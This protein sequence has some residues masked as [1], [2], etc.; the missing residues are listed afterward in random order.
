M[1]WTF[2]ARMVG[3]AAFFG[4]VA[5]ASEEH[6][7]FDAHGHLVWTAGGR[8]AVLDIDAG[9]L[10]AGGPSERI[11]AQFPAPEA[12][13]LHPCGPRTGM[14]AGAVLAQDGRWCAVR[15]GEDGTRLRVFQEGLRLWRADLPEWW[16]DRYAQVAL[17]SSRVVLYDGRTVLDVDGDRALRTYD[18]SA[19]HGA[20]A[21]YPGRSRIAFSGRPDRIV[22]LFEER[23]VEL[24]TLEVSDVAWRSSTVVGTIGRGEA[25]R[26]AVWEADGDLRFVLD[27]PDYGIR[28]LS[29]DGR[30]LGVVF[31]GEGE[32]RAELLD[33]RTGETT[34]SWAVCADGHR[35][36]PVSADAIVDFCGDAV[37]LRGPLGSEAVGRFPGGPTA[38]LDRPVRNVTRSDEGLRIVTGDGSHGLQVWTLPVGGGPGTLAHR[39]QWE[40]VAGKDGQT[41]KGYEG[42]TPRSLVVEKVEGTPVEVATARAYRRMARAAERDGVR[43]AIAS[44]FRTWEE[45]A[46]L[47]DC[48]LTGDCNGGN[49]AAPPGHSNHQS[50]LALDLNTHVRSV[51]K[52]L[53]QHAREYGFVRTVRSEPWHWEYVGGERQ[54]A[55]SVAVLPPAE[56]AWKAPKTPWTPA[57]DLPEPVP[58]PAEPRSEAVAE[59]S[60][61]AEEIEN[62]WSDAPLQRARPSNEAATPDPVNPFGG[63]P[64]N[65]PAR[66]ARDRSRELQSIFL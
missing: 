3:V 4:G 2:L 26:A 55:V 65:G 59:A 13:P 57:P 24:P 8:S 56:P 31:V 54:P 61:P 19:G 66:R 27:R 11:E 34:A 28:R 5:E 58:A 36:W 41:V 33:T 22:D 39:E 15:D 44:G 49:L 60:P 43:L 40:P 12:E 38:L 52:W 64:Q 20:M 10:L 47:Y 23:V 25:A 30:A 7:R 42:G 63:T 48:Y 14:A 50:G 35:I 21:F 16:G 9:V 53:E 46:A 17:T 29:P 1:H 32:R 62:P 37:W 51:R 18:A 45:Q 6:V